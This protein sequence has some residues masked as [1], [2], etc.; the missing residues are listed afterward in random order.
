[1]NYSRVLRDL[2]TEMSVYNETDYGGGTE[3]VKVEAFPRQGV[4]VATFKDEDQAYWFATDL[5]NHD[6]SGD[7]SG[8]SVAV[9]E[10][11]LRD[12]EEMSPW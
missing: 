9:D 12:W 3:R 11:E 4:V 6:I 10:I 1:M 5:L 8:R 2:L 7:V